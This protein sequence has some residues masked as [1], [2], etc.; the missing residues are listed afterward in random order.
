MISIQQ[1]DYILT[2]SEE[3]HFQRASELCY[4]TQPTLSMQLKKAE[5][6]LGGKLFD[7]SRNPLELTSFGKEMLPIFRDVRNEYERISNGVQRSKGIYKEQI[8]L[9]IIPTITGYMIPDMYEIWNEELENVQLTIEEM[10]TEDLLLALEQKKIDVAI[11]AGPHLSQRLRTI[12]L[13]QEEIKAYYPSRKKTTVTTSDLMSEHPWLLTQGNC[14]RTQMMHFCGLHDEQNEDWDYEGGNMDL[15][16]QMVRSHGGYTLVPS[17]CIKENSKDYKTITS[18]N[19]EVPAREIIALT[20]NKTEKW[21]S[22]ERLI[23]SVQLKYGSQKQEENLNIL[24]WK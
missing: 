16:Q 6:M 23:R 20:Y 10:K 5:E 11:L 17:H 15:L 22:I 13:F 7:R 18:E 4:V 2:L 14:L 21:G 3:L 9:A 8:R 24:S 1:I 12:P 19:G